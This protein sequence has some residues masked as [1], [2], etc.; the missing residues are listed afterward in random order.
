MTSDATQLNTRDARTR[1]LGAADPRSAGIV[2]R[3]RHRSGHRL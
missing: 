1:L 2:P 3:R